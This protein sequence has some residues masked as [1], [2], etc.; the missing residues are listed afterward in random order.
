MAFDLDS[1]TVIPHLKTR[2]QAEEANLR[3]LETYRRGAKMMR[4]AGYATMIA[5]VPSWLWGSRNL[6]GWLMA[7]GLLA[8]VTHYLFGPLLDH[9]A[10]NASNEL[11]LLSENLKLAQERQTES[12]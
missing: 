3:G 10:K 8:V 2:I 5:A 6:A 12:P 7:Y 1:P 9:Y 11:T 4:W